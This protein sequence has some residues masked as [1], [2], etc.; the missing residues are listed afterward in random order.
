MQEYRTRRYRLRRK[1]EGEER[2]I[3][4]SEGVSLYTELNP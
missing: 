1:A 3:T 2:K 4:G